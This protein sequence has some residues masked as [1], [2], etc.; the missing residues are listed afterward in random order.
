[1]TRQLSPLQAV[2]LGLVVVLG[3]AAAAWVLMSVDQRHRLGGNSIAVEAGF[4]DIGG[5]DIGTRVRLQGI[6]VGEVT[7]VVPPVLPG[8]EV[9]LRMRLAGTVRHLVTCDAFVQIVGENLYGGRT[10][11]ILPGKADSAPIAD[12]ARLAGLASSNLTDEANK[13]MAKFNH[14][15]DDV[16]D[17]KGSLGM[18]VKDPTA[19]HELIGILTS[20]RQNADAVKSMPVVRDYVV[21]PKKELIRPDCQRD[22]KWFPEDALFTPGRAVLTTAGRKRLDEAAVWLNGHKEAGSEVLVAAFAAPTKSADVA[23]M[24]TQKQSEVVCDY[25]RKTHSVQ[26]TGWM[27]WSSRPVRPLGVGSSPPEVPD[28]EKLPP[29][30]VELLVF[31]PG[32]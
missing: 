19:Y 11:N 30:R 4:S 10:V 2:E 27:P 22:C 25:L 26:S 28:A 18:L 31:V 5:V 6:D 1:M 29:A 21:D 23:L 16:N 20:L 12:G 17:G 13:T 8:G 24:L 14:I 32:K 9:K 3:L 7:E 15:L